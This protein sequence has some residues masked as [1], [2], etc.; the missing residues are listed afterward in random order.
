MIRLLLTNWQHRWEFIMLA[1][2]GHRL[3]RFMIEDI[4]KIFG[5]FSLIDP[6]CSC[7]IVCAVEAFLST[8]HQTEGI[9]CDVMMK[10]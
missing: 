7:S 6:M 9:G 3:K 8:C 1:C 2:V 5:L 10:V 4:Y